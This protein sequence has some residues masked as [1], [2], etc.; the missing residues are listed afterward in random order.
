[1]GKRL[2]FA[3]VAASLLGSPLTAQTQEQRY[4]FN[5]IQRDDLAGAEARL[6]AARLE[7]PS[8]P[9]VLI[10]LA[11]VYS[12]TGRI[13]EA[14]TLYRQVLS[15][16]NVLMLTGSNQQLWSHQLAEKGLNRAR[17]MASR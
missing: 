16:Q 12:K 3:A 8:E 2:L 11:H 14:E 6:T 1:M 13:A 5:A 10:N 15:T 9:S 4:G 17:Q 7:Q